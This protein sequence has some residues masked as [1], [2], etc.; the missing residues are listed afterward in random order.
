MWILHKCWYVDIS[1]ALIHSIPPPRQVNQTFELDTK[2]VKHSNASITATE[3]LL[4]RSARVIL[5]DENG[6]SGAALIAR[7]ESRFTRLLSANW[8]IN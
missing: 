2:T 5:Q 3:N 8:T 7:I 1:R 4:R 6:R